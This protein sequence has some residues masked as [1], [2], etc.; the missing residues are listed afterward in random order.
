MYKNQPSDSGL[1]EVIFS[2]LFQ[3]TPF[4]FGLWVSSWPGDGCFLSGV[5][6]CKRARQAF[7]G[8]LL[9][10]DIGIFVRT[11]APCLWSREA[12]HLNWS[13]EWTWSLIGVRMT[14]LVFSAEFL[15]SSN[16]HTSEGTSDAGSLTSCWVILDTLHGELF[17]VSALLC[18]GQ[19]C[20]SQLMAE[21]LLLIPE[22]LTERSRLSSNFCASGSNAEPLSMTC[23]SAGTSSGL[24]APEPGS[25]CST[26]Y[27]YYSSVRFISQFKRILKMW[28]IN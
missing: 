5:R 25:Y 4:S 28:W 26:K 6:C 8:A 23:S 17:A 18:T 12:S 27:N 10:R 22:L 13:C 9:T 1:L 20:L 7:T 3:D 11:S 14:L 2:V 16:G 15:L 21:E 24:T 19:L